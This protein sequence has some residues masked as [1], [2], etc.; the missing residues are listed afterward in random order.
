MT[1][2]K[3]SCYV[4][5]SSQGPA[6]ITNSADCTMLDRVRGVSTMPPRRERGPLVWRYA[7]LRPATARAST[8]LR[9]ITVDAGAARPILPPAPLG[10]CAH[11]RQDIIVT[12]SPAIG[13]REPSRCCWRGGTHLGLRPAAKCSRSSAGPNRLSMS[14]SPDLAICGVRTRRCAACWRRVAGLHGVVHR[15]AGSP[16]RGSPKAGLGA[17]SSSS[18]DVITTRQRAAARRSRRCGLRGGFVVAV[19]AGAAQ[20]APRGMSLCRAKNPSTGCSRASPMSS[21]ARVQGELGCCRARWTP[22]NRARCLMPTRRAGPARRCAATI[23]SCFP[24]PHRHQP[25]ASTVPG[26]FIGHPTDRALFA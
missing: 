21:R 12:G 9:D 1:S 13:P 19:G 2:R 5:K 25:R 7:N 18:G 4:R 8:V 15:W 23:N 16:S 3:K 24:T 26:S 20:R 14:R 10:E 22:Q 17:W 11:E 6:R